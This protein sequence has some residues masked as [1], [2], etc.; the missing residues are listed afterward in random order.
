MTHPSHYTTHNVL[1]NP[2]YNAK[3]L[4]SAVSEHFIYILLF[5]FVSVC[6]IKYNTTFLKQLN[7][8]MVTANSTNQRPRW[9]LGF[10]VK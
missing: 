2:D 7:I 1:Q 8:S 10:W 5:L 3:S 6:V 4:R 9:N